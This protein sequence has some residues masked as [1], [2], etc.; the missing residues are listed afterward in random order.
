MRIVNI[1]PG[2]YNHLFTASFEMIASVDLGPFRCERGAESDHCTLSIS[3][4]K[5]LHFK[6]V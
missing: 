2:K 4:D 5:R 3:S 6:Q 1:K